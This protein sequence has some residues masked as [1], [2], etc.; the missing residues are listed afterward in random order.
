VTRAAL[1]LRVSSSDQIENTSL[2]TQERVCR[3]YCSRNDMTVVRVFTDAG[4]SAKTADR[5][6]FQRL[7]KYCSEPRNE[8]NFVVAYRLDRL[9]RNN[10]DYAVFSGALAKYGA[11]I[12]SATELITDDPTGKFMQTVLSAIAELDNTVRGQRAREGMR[13][14]VEKGGWAHQAPLGYENGR[15]TDGLP[16]L[17]ANPQR[18]PLIR[19]MFEL[20]ATGTHTMTNIRDAVRRRGWETVFGRRLH[21]QTVESVLKNP[22]YAGRITGL[23]A[24]GKVIKSNFVPMVDERTFDRVQT[25]LAG[26]GHLATPHDTQNQNFP[27]RHF[28][29]C[30]ACGRP[31]TASFATGRN[32][33]KYPYYRCRNS[34]CLAVHVKKDDL[35]RDFKLLLDAITIK[36]VPRL[37][38]FRDRV[39]DSWC[40]LTAEAVAE[41]ALQRK[42]MEDL[43]KQQRTLLDKLVKGVITDDAYASKTRELTVEIAVCKSGVHDADLQEAEVQS[44]LDG[45]DDLLRNIRTLWERLELVE[46]KQRFQKLLFPDGLTYTNGKGFENTVTSPIINVIEKDVRRDEVLAGET[47]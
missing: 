44:A 6:E 33:L 31:L 18:A 12:R 9:A 27:L 35:E 26:K 19:A 34:E 3:E 39:L 28:V 37:K 7:L 2:E 14:V 47:E 45:A 4:E 23:V 38:R 46:D 30:G 21:V 41:Q 29:R 25:I 42:R 24:M 17:V 36:T 1:Y 11:F 43:E 16:I 5:P 13:R 20:A 15:N 32:K 10:F 40:Q 22:I 8:V